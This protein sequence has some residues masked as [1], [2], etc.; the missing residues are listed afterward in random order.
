MKILLVTHSFGPLNKISSLRLMHWVKYWS[1]QGNHVTV[2]TTKKYKFDG[3]L[4][5]DTVFDPKLVDIHEVSYLNKKSASDSKVLSKKKSDSRSLYLLR[6]LNQFIRGYIGSL[7]DIHDLWVNPAEK[8]GMRLIEKSKF[9]CIV[10]SFSPP[11]SHVLASRLAKAGAIPWLAD[12]RD[13]WSDNHIGSAKF[14]FSIIEAR[15]ELN[16]VGKYAKVI[17]TVSA[18]LATTL[19]TKF[20]QPVEVVE[21][22]FDPDEYKALSFDSRI[23]GEGINIVYAG[24]IYP[25]RRDPEPLLEII[26][27][28]NLNVTIHFFGPEN[29]LINSLQ[30]K[31]KGFVKIYGN[32]SRREILNIMFSADILLLLES[33]AK[34]ADGVLTGK[35]FE[36]FAIER[37]ILGIGFDNSVLLGKVL[38]ESGAGHCFYKQHSELLNYLQNF[39]NLRLARNNEFISKFRR[40]VQ[41]QRILDLISC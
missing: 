21:N 27:S 39:N 1:A 26:K 37:P 24:N 8:V 13:L 16:T 14:P 23:A 19:Q 34:D 20:E 30:K 18:P 33:G 2:L 9:D 17:T 5:L 40:D 32:V 22:G 7:F 29:N 36:Y 12:Y 41:A 38:E 6:R 10:S 4:S 25:N 35:L 11:C 15:K 3:D 31:Y 28:N